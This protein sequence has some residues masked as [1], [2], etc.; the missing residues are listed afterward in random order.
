MSM[1]MERWTWGVGETLVETRAMH[2]V[3][4]LL[5]ELGQVVLGVGVLDVGQEIGAPA[6]RVG[7]P[8]HQVARGLLSE[9]CD[10]EPKR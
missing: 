5:A 8:A 1:A 6:N 3:S 10:P 7:A 9:V 2:L 4:D